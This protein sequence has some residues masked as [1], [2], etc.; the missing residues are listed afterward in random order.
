MNQQTFRDRFLIDD[1]EDDGY[2]NSPL[3]PELCDPKGP[4]SPMTSASI[5]MVSSLNSSMNCLNRE[6]PH[7][8]NL[9][10]K[11][12]DNFMMLFD[13]ANSRFDTKESRFQP[14]EPNILPIVKS[15]KDMYHTSNGFPIHE[16]HCD[17]EFEACGSLGEKSIHPQ[18]DFRAATQLDINHRLHQTEVSDTFE[19]NEKTQH[20]EIKPFHSISHIEKVE[21][22]QE[23]CS[24]LKVKK[25]FLRKGSRRE[26]SALYRLDLLKYDDNSACIGGEAAQLEKLQEL[27]KM[28][29]DQIEQL[30]HRISIRAEARKAIMKQK[31]Q[32]DSSESINTTKKA[33]NNHPKPKAS[34]MNGQQ[35]RSSYTIASADDEIRSPVKNNHILVS[36]VNE[37][38]GRPQ[39][40]TPTQ[41][42]GS[43]VEI[44]PSSNEVVEDD[45]QVN[46]KDQWEEQWQVIKCMRKRQEAALRDAERHREEVRI[47]S[48]SYKN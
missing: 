9:S 48:P 42:T 1:G 12:V 25:P 3:D 20:E 32:K 18:G 21:S 5:D 31:L 2:L 19:R 6:C 40:P 28:Q 46:T 15:Q 38:K 41:K 17:D 44:P 36:S 35:K 7:R 43:S 8:S 29:R 26:P 4:S 13:Q 30:E 24:R 47:S 37:N 16:V 22:I 45:A 27:E 10:D 14:N 33:D 34:S 11:I 23:D 39:D